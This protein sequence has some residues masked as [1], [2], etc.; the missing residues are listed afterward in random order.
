MGNNGLIKKRFENI[1]S[2]YSRWYDEFYGEWM[3]NSTNGMLMQIT[4]PKNPKCLD[5]GCGT[6]ISTFELVKACNNKG[7]FYGID[8]S[9][10]M[11]DLAK[12]KNSERGYKVNFMKGDAEKINLSDSMFDLVLC[13]MSFTYFPDKLKALAEAYRVLKSGGQ[14]AYAYNGGPSY[15]EGIQLALN[16]A[17]DYPDIPWFYE[18]ILDSKNMSIDL[19][20][21][22]ELFENVG[23]EISTIYGRRDVN[24]SDP[25]IVTSE[26]NMFWSAWSQSIP[27]EY[28]NAIGAEL[29]AAAKN[30]SSEKGFEH[31]S[32]EIFVWGRKTE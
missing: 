16:L 25:Y 21:S 20:T 7:I 8:I 15:Q 23:F 24:Y 17:L 14:F 10:N 2:I 29:Y 19:N 13:N 5:I 6:G 12:K 26:K 22:V 31:T 18:A 32:Y 28:V 9:Q 30:A 3:K 11:I 4:I 1:Y 27:E